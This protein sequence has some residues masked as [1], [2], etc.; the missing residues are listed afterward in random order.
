MTPPGGQGLGRRTEDRAQGREGQ[1]NEQNSTGT[2]GSH[3]EGF[4]KPSLG[5]WERHLNQP[6]LCPCFYTLCFWHGLSML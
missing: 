4:S 3:E 1:G 2:L 6:G 5:L